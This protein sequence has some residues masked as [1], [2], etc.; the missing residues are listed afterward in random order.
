[1]AFKWI[2]VLFACWKTRTP[3]DEATYLRA[4]ERHHSPLTRCLDPHTQLVW[5]EVAGFQKLGME[6]A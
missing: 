2:R 4:L 1:M 6:N 3:Y 5:K